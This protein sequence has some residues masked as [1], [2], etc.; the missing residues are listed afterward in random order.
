MD[1]NTLRLDVARSLSQV[2]LTLSNLYLRVG[3]LKNL[4]LAYRKFTDVGTIKEDVVDVTTVAS[5]L[6]RV[7]EEVDRRVTKEELRL[8]I[9]EILDE[10]ESRQQPFDFGEAESSESLSSL[11]SASLQRTRS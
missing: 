5:A 2:C 6:G 8:L 10:R 1:I 7:C 3:D 9:N 11:V 4:P